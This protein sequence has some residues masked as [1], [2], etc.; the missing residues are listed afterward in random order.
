MTRQIDWQS[1]LN[2]L[3]NDHKESE[4]IWGTWDC[5]IFSAAICDAVLED[6]EDY[7]FPFAGKYRTA[8][9]SLRALKK[10]GY[11]NLRHCLVT[12][13]G[14]PIGPSHAWRGDIAFYEECAGL[15]LGA[16]NLLL[17]VQHIGVDIDIA[18]TEQKGFVQIPRLEVQEYFKVR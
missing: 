17:G 4:F 8:I 1:N 7:L 9:G 13:F 14:E 3:I 18:P 2:A 10:A 11:D 15:N 12:C 16:Y 5:G 6:G